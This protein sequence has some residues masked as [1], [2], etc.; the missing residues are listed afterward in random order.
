MKPCAAC[1][2]PKGVHAPAAYF[3]LYAA[4]CY[5]PDC[6]CRGW[7]DNQTLEQQRDET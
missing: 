1:H 5:H 3:P 6:R 4:G 7:H 2:H